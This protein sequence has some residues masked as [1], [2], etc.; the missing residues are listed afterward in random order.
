[1]Q[2]TVSDADGV[3]VSRLFTLGLGDY[4][5]TQATGRVLYVREGVDGVH[6]DTVRRGIGEAVATTCGE[7]QHEG[8]NGEEVLFHFL[9]RFLVIQFSDLSNP[10]F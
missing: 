7:G 6:Q 10:L 2:T 9:F 4:L 8:R 3:G 1:M 5:V